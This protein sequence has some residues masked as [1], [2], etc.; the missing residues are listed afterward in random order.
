VQGDKQNGPWKMR[1]FQSVE[2]KVRDHMKGGLSDAGDGQSMPGRRMTKAD[3]MKQK[4]QQE[5]A[6]GAYGVSP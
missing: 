3:Q 6:G 2:S 5:R 1:R 4:M